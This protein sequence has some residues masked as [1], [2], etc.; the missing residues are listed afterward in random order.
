MV[1]AEAQDFLGLLL[2]IFLF[3]LDFQNF[4]TDHY[5]FRLLQK[6]KNTNSMSLK[7]EKS[8]I[9]HWEASYCSLKMG[10]GLH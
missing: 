9:R 2:P 7:L 3:Y 1:I 6:V 5:M 4:H 10:L 8:N